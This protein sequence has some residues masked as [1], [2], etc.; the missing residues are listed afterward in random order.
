MPV[1]GISVLSP[2]IGFFAP[3]SPVNLSQDMPDEVKVVHR[4]V[5]GGRTADD[6]DAGIIGLSSLIAGVRI[7]GSATFV[8]EVVADDAQALVY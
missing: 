3:N 7:A 4:V 1:E 2:R 5:I 8:A 6:P